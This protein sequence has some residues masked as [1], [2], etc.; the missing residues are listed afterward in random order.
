MTTDDGGSQTQ[1][2]FAVVLRGAIAARGISLDQLRRALARKGVT[3][4]V[5]TL[6]YWQS[7]RS[8][9]ERATSLA[10]I[11]PLEEC[12]E[13]PRGFLAS[14]LPTSRR[15]Q[16]RD[17]E[18]YDQAQL[19]DTSV[20]PHHIGQAVEQL[21][22]DYSGATWVSIHDRIR[23]DRNRMETM[24]EVRL[25]L[26]A[27]RDGFDRFP[28]WMETDDPSIYPVITA[29]TNCRVGRV[30]EFREHRGI[31]VEMLLERPLRQE[32]TMLVEHRLSFVGPQ[33]PKTYVWR[34]VVTPSR[35][36]VMEIQFDPETVPTS[37]TAAAV[38]DGVRE[39]FAVPVHRTIQAHFTD[40]PPGRF[41]LSWTW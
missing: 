18:F 40:R 21:D 17:E 8:R 27:R 38:I 24:H 11:G 39:E 7:G 12:L 19:P 5:A 30:R 25:L 4:S 15:R 32:E 33:T 16:T 10:A 41:H 22:L 3:V 35:E 1:D 14:R 28:V 23:L 31:A 36:V 29:L 20:R 6:S 9:P 34:R 13:L 37:A 26:R 2:G